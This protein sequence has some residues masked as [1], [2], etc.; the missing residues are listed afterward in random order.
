MEELWHHHYRHL[1]RL[2]VGLTGDRG[3]A[4]EIVQDAFAGLILRWWRLRDQESAFAYLRSTVVNASRRHWKRRQVA[5]R[6]AAMLRQPE[7]VVLPDVETRSDLLAA[8]S[9]L[10]YGKR[11]CL[12]LRY[13]EDLPEAQ[14]AR[15]LGVSVG[16]VKSQCARG[17]RQLEGLLAT[18][19]KQSRYP[20]GKGD[21][22]DA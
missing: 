17:L 2:A 6:A 1:V 22:D 13:Y 20:G 11:A 4:E 5:D 18:E 8:L 12:V 15:L 9:R 3:A 14:V 10:P 7:S 16:T 21:I 19:S